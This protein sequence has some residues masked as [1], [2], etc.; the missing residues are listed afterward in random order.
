M[1]PG[2]P[3]VAVLGLVADPGL[4]FDIAENLS[5]ELPNL[6]AQP[7]SDQTTWKVIAIFRRLPADE[8]GEIRLGTLAQ[9]GA[10]GSGFDLVIFLTDQPRRAGVRPVVAETS[11]ARGV[12]LC[13][14]RL[15]P[16]QECERHSERSRGTQIR[17]VPQASRAE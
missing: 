5:S 11:V 15:G 13:M 9:G 4:T 16:E 10:V 7:V 14:T 12:A 17:G 6:L 1:P 3:G 2:R 8:Q